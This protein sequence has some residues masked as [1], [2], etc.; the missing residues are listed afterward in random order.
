MASLPLQWQLSQDRAC[1][2]EK[3]HGYLRVIVLTRK[4]YLKAGDGD[5]VK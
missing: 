2:L 1:L 3:M 4:G 5:R